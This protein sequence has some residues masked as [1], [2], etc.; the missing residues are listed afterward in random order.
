MTCHFCGGDLREEM[1]TFVDEDNGKLIV[2]CNV[3]ALVCQACGEKE[4][5]PA[6][7]HRL[8]EFVKRSPRPTATLSVPLYDMALN[9]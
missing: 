7:T 5:S 8:Y 6:V 4:Y 1:T 3:P 9:Q 2:V